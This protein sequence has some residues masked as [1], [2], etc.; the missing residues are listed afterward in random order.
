[1]K[2]TVDMTGRKQI[3]ITGA[4]SYT[5]RYITEQ[6]IQRFGAKNLRIINLNRRKLKNP[7][8]DTELEVVTH[9]LVFDNRSQL[10]KALEGSSFFVATYWMRFDHYQTARNEVVNN[11]KM[12]VDCA[13]QA[14]VERY[15]YTSHTQAD[16]DCH[17]PYIAG[18][19][20]VETHVKEQFPG[21]YGIVKPCTIFGDT[22]EESIVI[23]NIAYLLRTFPVMAIVG[24]GKYPLHPVH[25]RDMARLCIEAGIDEHGEGEYD[26]DAVNPE[27]T[28]F[29]DL[30]RITRDTLGTN[31]WLQTGVPLDLA[32]WCTKP[33]NWYHKDILIDKTDID[34]MTNHITCS[35]KEPLGRIR[36]SD[37]IRENKDTLGRKYISSLQRYYT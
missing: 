6:L 31:C 25:V 14:G 30:L 20:Q 15:V 10:T 17:V 26:L 33:L 11:A 8:Q 13:K 4:F 35:H 32:F 2:L 28:N 29:I 7:F 23:N 21:S 5:G 36:Y 16:V 37:W 1:M 18:K 9:P 24:D 34:L 3:A 19:A 22:P 12:L 27:K